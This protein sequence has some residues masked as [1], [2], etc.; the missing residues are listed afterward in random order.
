MSLFF[1]DDPVFTVL[2]DALQA[3]LLKVPDERIVPLGVI[4]KP[5]IGKAKFRTTLGTILKNPSDIDI[6]DNYLVNKRMA[7]LSGT[8]TNQTNIATGLKILNDFLKGFGVN[9]PNISL[10]FKE[11]TNVTFSFENVHRTWMDNGV[12]AGVLEE[13]AIIK[14]ALTKGFFGLAS[15]KLLVIDSIITSN[16]FSIHVADE[17]QDSFSFNAAVI[18]QEINKVGGKIKVFSSNKRSLTFKGEK[19]LPFAFTCLHFKI[20]TKGAIIEMPPYTKQIPIVMGKREKKKMEKYLL[21][22][23]TEFIEID[24]EG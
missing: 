12:L 7:S 20:N 4:E 15:N 9:L 22:Q 17:V 10:H 21:T 3:N 8:E 11:V 2:H 13:Q 14:N 6:D 1:K 18:E 24:F 5:L 16:D 23:A 19:N